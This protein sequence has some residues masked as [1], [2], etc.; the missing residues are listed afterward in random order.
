MK[1]PHT[2]IA[3][4]LYG[5]LA[6]ID[7]SEAEEDLPALTKQVMASNMMEAADNHVE[8]T[9]GSNPIHHVIYII[10]ENRT[11]DQISVIW[12]WATAIHP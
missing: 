12:A 10:R 2:Y 9:T 7:R 11:Y 1:G 8:F 6:S 4:L 5:S 3:T